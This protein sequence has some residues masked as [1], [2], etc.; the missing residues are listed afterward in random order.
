MKRILIVGA[1]IA[2]LAVAACSSSGDLSSPA[3]LQLSE[4]DTLQ[5]VSL[6]ASDATA[7]DVDLMNAAEGSIDATTSSYDLIGAPQVV[8]NSTAAAST[9]DS[10]R[11]AFWGFVGGCAYNAATGRF[12][13]PDVVKDGLT[14]SRSA[15]FADAT[16]A[17]MS[18]YSDTLTASANFQLGVAGVHTTIA[19]A[20]SISRQRNMTATGLAGHE[21]TRTWNGTGTRT[22]GGYALD[23]L[24]TR[25]YHTQDAT[26]FANIV[27]KLPRGQNPWPLSGTITR[28]VNGS[29]SV[30]KD[31]VTRTFT[32]AKTV[33]VTFNG[34]RLVPMTIGGV[35][36]TLDL[37]TGKAVRV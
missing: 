25:S 6:S 17:A 20:D 31:G 10:P 5:A 4:N 18:H 3:S 36:F 2:T 11:F 34:T 9:A 12:T 32:V 35:A 28:Q 37:L 33:V 21:T 30:A 13:C 8:A 27:V 1:V 15:A 26:T 16:G 22:D 29:A 23:T 14:L 24:K 7:E 19:G